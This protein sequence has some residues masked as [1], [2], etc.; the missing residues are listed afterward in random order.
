MKKILSTFITIVSLNSF[1]AFA[2]EK[3]EVKV[4]GMVCSFCAQGIKKKFK[5]HEAVSSIDVNLDDKW[6]RLEVAD[7]KT[8]S[9]AEISKAIK[10]A[11]YDI[12]SIE[13][14]AVKK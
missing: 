10:D 12:V 9:D 14:N 7:S 3:I 5:G 1:L 2:G 4:K 6:V 8:L 13:R 11:G